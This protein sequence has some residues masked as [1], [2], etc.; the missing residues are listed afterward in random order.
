M[1][2]SV[3]H[4]PNGQSLTVSPIFGGMYVRSNDLIS[5]NH[6]QCPFPPGW[7]VVLNTEEEI[8][9]D[10]GS[11]LEDSPDQV[12]QDSPKP[13]KVVRKVIHP[14]RKPT[15]QSDHLFISSISQPP[16]SEFRPANSQAR[17]I[18]MMLWATLYWY[19]QQLEPDPHPITAASSKTPLAGRPKGEWRIRINREGVFKSRVVLP[20][21][22]RMGLI[23]SLDSAVGCDRDERTGEGYLE[24]FVSRRSF[25]QLDARIYLF[26]LAPSGSPFPGGTPGG[27]PVGSR[28]GSPSRHGDGEPRN[29]NNIAANVG[30]PVLS[31]AASPGPFT[32]TSHLP[33]YYPPPPTQFTYTEGVRHPVR[34]KPGRQGEVVYTR[35]IPSVT[36]YL[37][38]RIAS[39][40]PHTVPQHRHSMSI[41][42]NRPTLSDSSVPTT[43]SLSLEE[44]DVDLLHKWMNE[45]RVSYFW[46][47]Q[48]PTAHQEA[49][50]KTA[51]HSK[52]SIPLIGMWDGK[53]FGYFEIYWVKEDNLGKLLGDVGNYDRG[54]HC[55]IGEQEYRGP[56]RVKMWLS[57]LVH[58]CWMADLRT[59]VVMME[60]R[61]DNEK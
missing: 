35:Y 9:E 31:G 26:T 6:N 21:L 59:E 37:S 57:S 53:P 49:F 48:G 14:W 36:Q 29:D 24:M 61:V 5:H 19:F 7:T 13:K 16:S 38:F 18:A 58:Y 30:T 43:L 15:L 27:T 10:H 41:I 22:E 8:E 2:P 51:L 11:K 47:E 1:A 45:P 50:L 39:V 46:G 54:I 40:T 25:W 34:P 28:P 20:K 55:L 52:H 12:G 4:L 23:A 33:T 32:S 42:A 17:Q 60:P 3:V 56:H 44:S